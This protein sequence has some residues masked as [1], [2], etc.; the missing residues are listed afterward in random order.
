MRQNLYWPRFQ[1]SREKAAL[2]CT[3]MASKHIRSVG[4]SV[5]VERLM[6]FASHIAVNLGI[7]LV[8]LVV[9]FVWAV[10][11]YA[12]WR[13]ARAFAHLFVSAI[14]SNVCSTAA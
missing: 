1:L 13:I 6:L 7:A 14:V 2:T 11:M 8:L 3:H 5:F 12:L 10:Q 4:G 9:I